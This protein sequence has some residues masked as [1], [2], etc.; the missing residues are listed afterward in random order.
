M[1]VKDFESFTVPIL[2]RVLRSEEETIF[3]FD[4]IGKMELMSHDFI[5]LVK[6]LLES[7]NEKLHVLGTVAIKGPGFIAESKGMAEVVEISV[8]DRDAKM[9]EVVKRLEAVGDGNQG[10]GGARVRGRWRPKAKVSPESDVKGDLWCAGMGKG[11][12][13]QLGRGAR[14]TS[15]EVQALGIDAEV[16]AASCGFDHTAVVL[17][18]K[19]LLFGRNNRGQCASPCSGTRSEKDLPDP[20]EDVLEPRVPDGMPENRAVRAVSCGGDHTL[21][22]FESG[23]VWACGDNSSGQLGLGAGSKMSTSL[24]RCALFP[25][26][27]VSAGFRHSAAISQEKLYVWGGNQQGQL[28]LGGRKAVHEPTVLELGSAVRGCALGRWHTLAL[29]SVV[30]A[31]GWGRFGVLAQGDVQDHQRPVSVEL[32]PPVHHVASGAVH[33]GAICGPKRQCY[34]WGRGSLGRCGL[35]SEANVMRPQAILQLEDVA[36][37]VLGGDFSAAL[38]ATNWWLWGKNEEGQL[39]FQDRSPHLLPTKSAA[40]AGFRHLALGDCHTLA[41]R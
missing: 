12:Y 5:S 25:A 18:N 38:S 2:E 31:F 13:G 36:S 16:Q 26:A 41:F 33:C 20:S 23:D 27:A 37:L 32:P 40:L 7:E 1:Q 6:R 28:G 9:L 34:M 15:S 39:G 11:L 4:E 14:E 21:V 29:T 24:T 35:G 22:L 3:I 8:E 10:Y 19:L 17:C 30:W